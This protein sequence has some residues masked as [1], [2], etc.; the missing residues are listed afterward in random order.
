MI[1][2]SWLLDQPSPTAVVAC[3][4][5][6]ETLAR[7]A[8]L[9]GR[10]VLDLCAEA[11]RNAR[12]DEPVNMRILHALIAHQARAAWRFALAALDLASRQIPVVVR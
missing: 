10:N 5:P 1:P 2:A 8:A 6:A 4:D 11:D 3:G 7:L 9:H 12:A